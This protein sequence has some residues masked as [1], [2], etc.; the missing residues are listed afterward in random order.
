MATY[1]EAL[2]KCVEHYMERGYTEAQAMEYVARS[3]A[4]VFRVYNIIIEENLYMSQVDWK[5][6]QNTT[7]RCIWMAI[8]QW[9]F[10]RQ[11]TARFMRITAREQIFQK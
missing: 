2:K 8:P 9:R 5:R 1:E 6:C 4:E 7:L 3:E 10:Y 11:H